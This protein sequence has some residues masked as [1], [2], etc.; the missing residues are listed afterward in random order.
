MSEDSV[1]MLWLSFLILSFL[2]SS[3]C[4]DITAGAI[5]GWLRAAV[6]HEDTVPSVSSAS[7][8]CNSPAWDK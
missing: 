7:N 3:S 2:H 1:L 5:P 8:V 6:G 4:M